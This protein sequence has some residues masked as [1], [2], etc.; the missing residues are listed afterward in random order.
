MNL[1]LSELLV[2]VV[3]ELQSCLCMVARR[4]GWASH[5]GAALC[6]LSCSE[7]LNAGTLILV[8]HLLAGTSGKCCSAATSAGSAARAGSVKTSATTVA[9][10]AGIS[11]TETSTGTLVAGLVGTEGT[12]DA[13]AALTDAVAAA[14]AAALAGITLQSA[15]PELHPG[16]ETGRVVGR[17]SKHTLLQGIMLRHQGLI[18]IPQHRNASNGA[19]CFCWQ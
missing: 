6:C 14:V 8:F 10:I 5:F 4:R 17:T 1:L 19:C 9:A 3:Y 12:T 11:T 18:N 16:T 7:V 13:G 2:A 15:G